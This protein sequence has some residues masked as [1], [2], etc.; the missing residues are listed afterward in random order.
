[1]QAQYYDTQFNRHWLL[2]EE[3]SA[4]IEAPRLIQLFHSEKSCTI[5]NLCKTKI[6][7]V[8]Y[9]HRYVCLCFEKRMK[10]W[11]HVKYPL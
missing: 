10:I 1:M 11:K 8:I 3:S 2:D 4:S 7:S 5:L 9:L 6:V